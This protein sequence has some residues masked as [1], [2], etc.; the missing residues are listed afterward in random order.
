SKH[1]PAMQLSLSEL[2]EVEPKNRHLLKE[3]LE[4]KQKYQREIEL[5]QNRYFKR[6]ID[7]KTYQ[8]IVNSGQAKMIEI[9]ARVRSIKTTQDIKHAFFDLKEKLKTEQQS[10]AKKEQAEIERIAKEILSQLEK[11]GNNNF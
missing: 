7:E 10:F 4:E 1:A 5:A 3:L 9:D 11:S 2:A 8:G 6:K